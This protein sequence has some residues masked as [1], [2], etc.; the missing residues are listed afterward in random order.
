MTKELPSPEILRKLLRYEP[1]TG[2]L[3]WRIRPIEFCTSSHQCNAWNAKY[4]NKEA[5][6]TTS[7]EGY[8]QGSIFKRQYYAHRV[9]W[10]MQSGQWPS[11]EVDHINH[12]RSNN[13]LKNLRE[14]TPGQ[15]QTN[16]KPSKNG[17]SKYLG[18]NWH[19]AAC[20]WMACIRKNGKDNYLGLFTCE[21]EAAR[22][23]DAAAVKIH[24][25][26]ASLNC[27]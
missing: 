9:I 27:V 23:Y 5:F 21:V 8:K 7:S 25:E 2:K 11:H 17:S 4:A 18:V 10:A 14:A 26:F 22:A 16:R 20:K 15:N 3:F 6:T 1:E 19:K 24:G 12:D 13:A